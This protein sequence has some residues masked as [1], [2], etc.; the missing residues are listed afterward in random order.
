M[1]SFTFDEGIEP[2]GLRSRSEIKLLVCYL[3]SGVDE[4][5]TRAQ[6]CEI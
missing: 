6:L 1:D 4:S 2:G 5:I 3:L